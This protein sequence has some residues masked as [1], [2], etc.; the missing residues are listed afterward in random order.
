[1]REEGVMARK[2]KHTGG[3]KLQQTW[4]TMDI[5]AEVAYVIDRAQEHVARFVTLGPLV[6]FSTGTVHPSRST[7]WRRRSPS[8]WPG[9]GTS[10]LTRMCS[11]PGTSP[12]R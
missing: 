10:R 2:R 8:P 3:Q 6:F 5:K 4:T 7:S 9:I 1:M 12:A 11:R